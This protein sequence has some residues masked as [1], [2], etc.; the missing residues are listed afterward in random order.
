MTHIDVTKITVC[1]K[2]D[3]ILKNTWQC[4]LMNYINDRVTENTKEL[5]FVTKDPRM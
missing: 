4:T 2:K 1:L 3:L 5:Y